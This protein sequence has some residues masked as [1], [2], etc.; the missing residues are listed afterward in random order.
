MAHTTAPEPTKDQISF[1]HH[2][3]DIYYDDRWDEEMSLEKFLDMWLDNLD[4]PYED[5][6]WQGFDNREEAK[7][8]MI[9]LCLEIDNG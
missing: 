9:K 5:I 6:M 4:V 2:L 1:A 3:C 7:A 8:S